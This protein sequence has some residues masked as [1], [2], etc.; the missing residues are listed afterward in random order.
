[1]SRCVLFIVL[2]ATL[3]LGQQ[4]PRSTVGYTIT[5]KV[6][7]AQTG[8][9]LG[10][11][12][13]MIALVSDR[14]QA[15]SVVA[16][17]DGTFQFLDLAAGKYALRAT[18]R[19]YL[20]QSFHEH[21]G[22]S[23]AVVAGPGLAST[24]LTFPLSRPAAI[25]GSVTDQD[26]EP[27]PY[28]H[29]SLFKQEIA[30]G[31]RTA[32]LI[33][34]SSSS[35]DGSFHMSGLAPGAYYVALSAQPWYARFIQRRHGVADT[36]DSEKL[37]IAYPVMFYPNTPVADSAAPISLG[38]GAQVQA[39]FVMTGVPAA[40]VR[41]EHPSGPVQASRIEVATP[42][43]AAIP[44]GTSFSDPSADTYS[45]APGR[46]D[47]NAIWNDASGAHSLDRVIDVQG[48]MTVDFKSEDAINLSGTV[49]GL[50]PL[51]ASASIVLVNAASGTMSAAKRSGNGQLRWQDTILR[52]GKYEV[53]LA[54]APGYYIAGISA[55]G[56]KSAGR[57]VELPASGTVA[58]TVSIGVGAATL[59]GTVERVGK[60]FAGAMVLLLPDDIQ[61]SSGL[62]RRDQSDSDGTFTLPDIVPGRYTLIAVE[63]DDE[64]EY[65]NPTAIQPYLAHGQ[66]MNIARGGKYQVTANLIATPQPPAAQ[67]ESTP[68]AAAN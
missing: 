7:D 23:T 67:V 41:M 11:A 10:G 62:T 28:A 14:R 22:Y 49:I 26:N 13:V 34:Q 50:A 64:L 18:H 68:A 59:N 33:S 48:D 31:F 25:S 56:A 44:I 27:V 19:G 8:A 51:P 24:G 9:A 36:P 58:L 47:I 66:A 61:H 60:P 63:G 54:Q 20:T 2:C 3:A 17:P 65:S 43:G 55:T 45:V 46:Y 16:R 53:G 5:G 4:Q 12:E 6:V 40:H 30:N 29:V 42:W 38:P 57:T 37:D 1:M 32:R 39:D 21:G 15:I 35:D 52:A